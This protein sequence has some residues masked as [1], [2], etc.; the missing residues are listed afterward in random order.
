VT[1]LR[2]ANKGP[3]EAR[4]P[5]APRGQLVVHPVTVEQRRAAPLAHKRA[6]GAGT[7]AARPSVRPIRAPTS[8]R[9]TAFTARATSVRRSNAPWASSAAKPAS[10]TRRTNALL[11][12]RS[13]KIASLRSAAEGH[14]TGQKTA[15]GSSVATR[16]SPAPARARR[17]CRP[18]GSRSAKTDVRASTPMKSW[19][20]A[21]PVTAW[22]HSTSASGDR[23]CRTSVPALADY[24]GL[25]VSGW[26]L[27]AAAFRASS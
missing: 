3:V 10:P 23:S 25:C 20:A 26:G 15:P 21:T 17:A 16:K 22:I 11:R 12:G 5:P 2:V 18:M 7:R 9:P 13:A 8:D 6:A 14:A 1:N 19:S 27:S 4:L 24:I